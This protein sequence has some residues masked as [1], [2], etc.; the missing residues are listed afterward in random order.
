[1]FWASGGFEWHLISALWASEVFFRLSGP[2]GSEIVLQ[3]AVPSR[4]SGQ[5]QP[6]TLAWWPVWSNWDSPRFALRSYSV[7]HPLRILKPAGVGPFDV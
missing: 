6:D 7:L 5:L 4:L 3:V 1:M 2:E